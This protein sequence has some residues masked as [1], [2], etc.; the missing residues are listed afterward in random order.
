MYRK[1]RPADTSSIL[2][3]DSLM[4]ILSCLVGV[5]L[6]LVIYT[7]LELGSTTYE[8][9]VPITRGVPL[10]S[11][12]VIVLCDHGTVR[13]MDA[14]GPVETLLSGFEIVEFD[15]AEAFVR[16]VNEGAPV[17]TYFEYSLEFEP[18]VSAFLSPLGTLDL[19]I[20]ERPGLVGDSIHQLDDASRYTAALSRLDPDDTWLAF[21]VDS[22]SVDVFR[23]AREQALARGFATNFDP[24]SVIFPVTHTL[25]D[26]GTESLL[27]L[28]NTSSKPER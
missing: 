18:R 27:S 24:G 4:D 20:E 12:R 21:A 17:D 13:V 19:R 11:E 23:R 8:A 28:S 26:G 3:L 22:T 15:E 7:V 25:S 10:G 5:M 2:D 9:T 16:Q 14:R 1:P 6:F